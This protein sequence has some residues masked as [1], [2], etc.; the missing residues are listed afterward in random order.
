MHQNEFLEPMTLHWSHEAA[1]IMEHCRNV[2]ASMTSKTEATSQEKPLYSSVW[3]TVKKEIG[4]AYVTACVSYCL[5]CTSHDDFFCKLWL[6][7]KQYGAR[8]VCC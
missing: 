5:R 7:T 3:H 4:V 1:L 8:M 6:S 2:I